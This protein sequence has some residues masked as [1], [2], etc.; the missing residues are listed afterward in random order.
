MSRILWEILNWQDATKFFCLLL[1]LMIIIIIIYSHIISIIKMYLWIG[2]EGMKITLYY[3]LL[4]ILCWQSKCSTRKLEDFLILNLYRNF[5]NLYLCTHLI[6]ILVMLEMNRVQLNLHRMALKILCQLSKVIMVVRWFNPYPM[7]YG[8]KE[9]FLFSL[10]YN[11]DPRPF[12]YNLNELHYEWAF[13]FSII[14]NLSLNM[15]ELTS[16]T[17]MCV[18]VFIH[19][20]EKDNK[21]N[22][23]AIKIK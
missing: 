1:L 7:I 17:L 19:H 13:I 14:R 6:K 22:K 16:I 8:F 20:R 11:N 5:F 10:Y 3:L 9:I 21:S 15:C 2:C 4:F 18:S 12:S 23:T